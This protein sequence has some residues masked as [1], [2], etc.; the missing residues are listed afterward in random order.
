MKTQTAEKKASFPIKK[1]F[2]PIF[3]PFIGHD[4]R[5]ETTYMGTE[6]TLTGIVHAKWSFLAP[7]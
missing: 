6:G 5:Q 2:W 1:I 4:K 3:S 7:K